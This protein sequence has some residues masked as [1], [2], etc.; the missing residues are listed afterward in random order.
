MSGEVG[1][2]GPVSWQTTKEEERQNLSMHSVLNNG[3][4]LKGARANR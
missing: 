1:R 3:R 2:H 4:Y